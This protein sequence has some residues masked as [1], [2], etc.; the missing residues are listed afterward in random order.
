M[1]KY[2]NKAIIYKELKASW[3]ITIV[4]LILVAANG[5]TEFYTLLTIREGIANIY[6]VSTFFAD[7]RVLPLIFVVLIIISQRI[8]GADK[9][10]DFERVAAMPFT[11]KETIVSK[12]V[13][14]Q[15]LLIIPMMI[16]SIMTL[17][18]YFS[19]YTAIHPYIKLG[20]LVKLFILNFLNYSAILM[21]LML[22]QSIVGKKVTG[23]VLGAIFMFVPFGLASFL[24]FFLGT[25]L[26]YFKVPAPAIISSGVVEKIGAYLLVPLYNQLT[27][28]ISYATR[29]ILLICLICVFATLTYYSYK[30]NQFERNGNVL[31]F[32]FLEPIFK[33][34]VTVF[35]ALGGFI[36][37]YQIFIGL[38]YRRNI[39]DGGVLMI[40]D[41]VLLVVGV[42]AYFLTD[43]HIKAS[44]E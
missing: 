44:R 26:D 29:I 24:A 38:I 5:A 17:L 20:I 32:G 34:G 30:K 33:L 36:F 28:S 13:V 10:C 22:I 43:K 2:L 15:L 35:F 39:L 19:N 1:K 27:P 7:A 31:M 41:I 42:L 3:Q 6:A 40:S 21:F 23:S 25:H 12:L 11:R 4:L 9:K 14:G 37:T 8:M 16:N 18:M